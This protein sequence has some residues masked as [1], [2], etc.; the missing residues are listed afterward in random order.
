[1]PR[2]PPRVPLPPYFQVAVARRRG[3]L[4]LGPGVRFGRGVRIDVAPGARITL[5]AGCAIGDRT[6]LVVRSGTL[7]IGA[8]ATL[9]ERCRIVVHAGVTIGDAAVL[10]DGAVVADFD[11]VFDDPERPIRLQGLAVA[12]VAIGAR[13]RVGDGAAVLRGVHI[14]ASASIDPRAVVTADVPAGARVGGVPACPVAI[15][16]GAGRP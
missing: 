3:R 16:D 6:R 14:G 10:C 2:L 4:C 13:A 8:G 5:G 1:M 9:G 7:Q 12:P 15:S 11:H